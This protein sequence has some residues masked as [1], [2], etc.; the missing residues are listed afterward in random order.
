MNSSTKEEPNYAS[1]IQKLQFK[2]EKLRIHYK[3]YDDT[4]MNTATYKF[5]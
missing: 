1:A 4:K 3:L 5:K 2:I